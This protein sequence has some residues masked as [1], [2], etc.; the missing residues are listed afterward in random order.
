[1]FVVLSDDL[2]KSLANP[3]LLR[4]ANKHLGLNCIY[5]SGLMSFQVKLVMFAKFSVMILSAETIS[6]PTPLFWQ[7][8]H[9]D[10]I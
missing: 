6:Y 10:V 4:L 9:G 2:M 5:K 8:K 7:R 1:M 3:G